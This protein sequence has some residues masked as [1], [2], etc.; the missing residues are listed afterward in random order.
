MAT[1][2]VRELLRKLVDQGWRIE[3]GRHY[4]AYPPDKAYSPVVISRTPSDHRSL[5]NAIAELRKRGFRP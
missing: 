3:E 4:R 5:K 2:E 1:K